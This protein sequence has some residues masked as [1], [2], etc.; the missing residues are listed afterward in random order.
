L[1][2]F[3]FKKLQIISKREAK[4]WVVQKQNFLHNAGGGGPFFINLF[5]E[6]QEKKEGVFLRF[7]SF[8]FQK[9]SI[10]KIR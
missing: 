8:F 6:S 1:W 10:A 4:A 9:K 3:F 2:K 7:P 5:L